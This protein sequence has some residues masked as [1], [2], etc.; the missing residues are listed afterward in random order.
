[1]EYNIPSTKCAWLN[2]YM[3]LAVSSPVLGDGN[4]EDKGSGGEFAILMI[5]P[6][7]TVR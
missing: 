7:N 3:L 2:S 6:N 5:A 4:S 1:V